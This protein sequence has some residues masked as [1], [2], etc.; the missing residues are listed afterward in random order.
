MGAPRDR[1][2][3]LDG[4]AAGLVDAVLAVALACPER[5]VP[6]GSPRRLAGLFR[7]LAAMPPDDP[8]ADEVEALIWALWIAHPR[9]DAGAAMGA[10][11][12][13]LQAGALDLAGGLLDRLVAEEPDWAEAWNK[14]ATLRFIEGRDA[15]S[16]ADIRETLLREPRH[17]GALSG[18]GQICLRGGR[19]AEARAAFQV[20]LAVNPHLQ[21]LREAIADLAPRRAGLH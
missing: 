17:F 1:G 5:P 15:D 8:E 2:G 13:A 6:E 7:R 21:G 19:R 12:E 14:R 10:A 11:I 3:G 20:A 9:E 18:L 4:A 16:L